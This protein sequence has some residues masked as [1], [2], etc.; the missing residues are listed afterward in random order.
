MSA[1]SPPDGPRTEGKAD[2]D[3]WMNVLAL[4][5]GSSSLKFGLYRVA[6][7]RIEMLLAG[8]AESI[9]GKGKF[10]AKDAHQDKIA[11]ETA[12]IP[13]QREAVVRI[14]KLL[15]TSGVPAPDAIGHRIVHGGPTLRQHCLIDASVMQE[16]EAAAVF[17]PLHTP[18]ALSVIRTAQEHFPGI[19]QA[20]CFDTA[21][22]AE[23]P[24]V[25]RVLP[26][27]KALQSEGI[28]RYGFHGLS[29][30]SI[31]HQLAN[32]LPH[33][34][35]ARL[36][37]RIVIA[38]LGNG[39]SV[40]AVKNGKSI[41]TSMGLTPTGGVIMGTR[42]GDLDPGVLVYLMRE[43]KFDA[44]MLEELVDHQSGLAGISG[45]GSDMRCLHEAAA[46]S[47]A[48]S[49]DARL[50]IDMFCYAVRKQIAA[51]IAVL[52]GADLIVFTGGIGENDAE[53]RASICSGLSWIGVSLDQARNR[54]A[55]NPISSP[56][57]RC[58]VQVL[59]SQEDEQIARHTWAV[60]TSLQSFNQ[61][62]PI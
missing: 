62:L 58:S 3:P 6:S 35:K 53:V 51:M 50:A 16:L 1:A 54:S 10:I 34:P 45:I 43:K 9:G 59:A 5:S 27:P 46:S 7:S 30:E 32:D 52:D 18:S 19:A 60:T 39:A 48:S 22:H 12:A 44:A 14:A 28:Q 31:L 24:E 49:A 36:P 40:T 2:A 42:S 41:D 20:A 56:A 25:A 17:A 26:V 37:E 8:A 11:A 57:S 13:S 47:A 23:L 21:F 4:N 38:H 15:G 61:E 33:D 29:Y 55:H